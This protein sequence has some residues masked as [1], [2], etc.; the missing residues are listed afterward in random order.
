MKIYNTLSK[1][2]EEIKPIKDKEIK[3][4]VCGITTQDYVHIGH[5]K[6]YSQFDFIV[7]YLRHKGYKVFYLQNITDID[8]RI[9]Q[10]AKEQKTNFRV[11]SDKYEK[12][13]LEGMATLKIDSVTKYAR[14]TDYIP[15]IVNQVKTLLKKDYAY[16]ID[17]GY[18]FDLSKFKEYGKLS[19]R[20]TLGEEDSVT[21][22]DESVNKK[23]KGDFCLWKF[24][25]K[26]EPSW[27][28]DIGKGRPGWHIEDTAITENFFGPQYDIHGGAID[29]IFPHHEAEIAQ[30]ESASGKKPLVRY[31]VHTGFLNVKGKKMSKSLK[32]FITVKEIL[33]KYDYRVIR[34]F[35]LTNHYRMPIDFSD[36]IIDQTKGALDRLNEFAINSKQKQEKVDVKLID[37]TKKQFYE[38][39][40]NDFDTPK[41][42]ATLFDFIR[43][44]NKIGPGQKCYEFLEEINNIFDFLT[45]QQEIPK[46]ILDL[47]QKRQQARQTKDFK[48]S[49]KLRKDILKKGYQI[50]DTPQGF[51]V[52]KI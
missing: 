44:A 41:A 36:E 40:D 50:D 3:F 6:T 16:K 22:I 39:L 49:D 15:Q 8:D 10:K 48:L 45:L 9:I 25:K 20:T 21:R 27:E 12:E 33:K 35:F 19:G 4:F 43:Q 30:M 24:S 29:L 23:N 38:H 51:V 13:Y 17:D 26:D 2:V 28:T 34:Y 32:N 47:A 7:K 52:K 46:E 5:A 37:N 18:Y 1:K 42:F 31:W 11:I 14:A